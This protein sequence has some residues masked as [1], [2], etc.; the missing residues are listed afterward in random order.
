MERSDSR[1]PRPSLLHRPAEA[2]VAAPLDPQT[3]RNLWYLL[4]SLPLG[5]AYLAFLGAG[6]GLVPGVLSSASARL[7]AAGE[8]LA[9]LAAVLCIAAG[10]LVLPAML[11]VL[12]LAQRLVRF[13]RRLSR[14]L[15][16]NPLA[17]PPAAESTFAAGP[18]RRVAARL[19]DLGLARGLTYIAIKGPLALLGAA[20]V[21]AALAT[22]AA[23]LLAPA[24][25]RSPLAGDAYAAAGIEHLGQAWLCVLVAFPVLG[26]ALQA[27]NGLAWVAR[28]LA[29]LLLAPT[30]VARYEWATRST[31]RRPSPP[32]DVA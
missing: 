7:A 25:Y 28:E 14:R 13:E 9:V 23:L 17:H 30:D 20:V 1:Q 29:R 32:P 10:V 24:L 3:Y 18:W 22:V 16:G 27:V 4:F 5:L 6:F 12:D 2:L 8:P 15:L 19:S 11:P 26:L 21:I 31:N